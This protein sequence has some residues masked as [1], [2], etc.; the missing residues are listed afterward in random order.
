MP[1]L[2]TQPLTAAQKS[3]L[4]RFADAMQAGAALRPQAQGR[5]FKQRNLASVGEVICSCALGAAWEGAHPAFDAEHWLNQVYAHAFAIGLSEISIYFEL[6][7][8]PDVRD[9]VV[10]YP[11]G[12][13]R[14]FINM[15]IDLNDFHEWTREDIA[16]WINML[17]LSG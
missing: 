13:Y 11:D 10:P 7:T 8:I 9:P 15:V 16:N 5:L 17:A 14:D 12:Y 6:S 2:F 1:A 3:A 4:K